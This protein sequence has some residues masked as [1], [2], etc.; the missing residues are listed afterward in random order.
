MPLPMGETVTTSGGGENDWTKIL[1]QACL[2][3]HRAIAKW[4]ATQGDIHW[5]WALS[6]N[7]RPTAFT[8]DEWRYIFDKTAA[9]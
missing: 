4:A 8:P 1:Y 3:S 9:D 7:A 6:N 5:S 2:S